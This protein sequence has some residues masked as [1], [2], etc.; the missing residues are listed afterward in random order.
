MLFLLA[1]LADEGSRIT[2][3]NLLPWLILFV[4]IFIMIYPGTSKVY[5][6]ARTQID[7]DE[8]HRAAVEQKLDRVI[9]LLEEQNER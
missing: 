8:A 7:R 4:I 1:E 9:E 3:L 5:R 6:A 2:L